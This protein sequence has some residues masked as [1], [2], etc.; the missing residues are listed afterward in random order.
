MAAADFVHGVEVIEQDSGARPIRTITTGVIGLVGTARQGPVHTPTLIA[1]SRREAVQQ[2]GKSGGTI[3]TA[4]AG[5]L[6]QV[7]APVVV[8]NAV[9]R[10][11]VAR[12]AAVF[13]GDTLQLGLPGTGRAVADVAIASAT[14]RLA[15]KELG[16]GNAK[17]EVV[18][19]TPGAGGNS[20][21]VALVD[22]GAGDAELVVEVAGQ[23]IEVSLA[24]DAGGDIASTNSDVVDARNASAAASALVIASLA[25][26]AVAGTVV[27]AVA[28]TNLAGG[29]GQTYD[30]GDDYTVDGDTGIVTRVAAGAIA[31]NQAVSASYSYLGDGTAADI[32]GSAAGDAYKGIHA[33]QQA[34]SLGLPRPRIL[35]APGFSSDAAVAGALIAVADK[36]R[37]IA[38]ADGPDTTDAEA[39]TYREN[40]DSRRLYLVDPA[41]KVGTPAVVEPASARVA[42]VI[43]R[44]DADRGFWW[45]PS[46]QPIVG[47]VGTS[48]P[49]DFRLGDASSRANHLNEN[50]VAT[51]IREDGYRLWGNRT[52]AADPKYQFLS[53]V[54]I[55][56]QINE[57]ILRGHLWAVDRNLTRTYLDDVVEGVNAFLR[58]LVGLGAIHGGRCWADP[59]LNPPESI[60]AGKVTFSFDFTP[61]NPAE[62]VTFHSV[63]T[64]DYLEGLL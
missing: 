60:A 45:S 26:G 23:A 11:V 9:E 56:D 58:E 13:T 57:R 7:G 64:N 47:V 15:E 54:R 16:A 34:E 42:G 10:E 4:L 55:A 12:A 44:T 18:A 36:L 2:F 35:I 17:I 8:V 29:V 1:G 19:A 25:M 48:R 14:S 50:A 22:P 63:L 5:I 51:V 38:I 62:R 20:I 61:V 6:D 3:P 33:L 40:F 37:A 27:A 28:A 53:V 41:L 31:A 39:V 30:L 46:N 59:D 52:T 24:T 32:A 49:V 21:T 43:A